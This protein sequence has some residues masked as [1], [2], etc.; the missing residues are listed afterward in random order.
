MPLARSLRFRS[1]TLVAVL[2]LTMALAAVLAYSA[3]DAQRSHRQIAERTLQDYASF[4][5]WEYG[6][7]FKDQLYSMLL[8]IFSPVVHEEKLAEDA[9]LKSPAVLL[10][11]MAQKPRCESD[12][13]RYA[14]RVDWPS[15]KLTLAGREPSAA[16][17]R[18]IR[19]TVVTT[20]PA[21]RHDWTYHAIYGRIDGE[22][23]VIAYQ[24]KWRKSGA[25]AA[26]YG[27]EF[28]VKTLGA[29]GFKKI[30]HEYN[31]LPPTLTK[32]AA[33]ESLFSVV[34]RDE[35]GDT[36]YKSARQ[37]P[38]RYAGDN[39][40]DYFGGIIT[41]VALNPAVA[42]D[43]VIGGLPHSRLALLVG[44]LGL[45]A[46]LVG[47]GLLQLRR[48]AEL[49]RL[50]ADFIASVS[51]ELRTPLAQLRM[52]AETLRL[53]R[54]RSDGERTRSLEIID[55]EARRLTHLVE[56]ILQFSRAERHAL[57]LAPC[58][59]L[60]APQVA[61]ALESF[62]PIARAR[63]ASLDV[64]L[65]ESLSA[66]VDP[67]AFRQ[68]LLN[69][70][71]NAVKY[72]PPGQRIRVALARDDKQAMLTVEDEGPGI[73]AEERERVWT[74]F[75]RLSR[76]VDSAVAGSGIGLSVVRELVERHGGRVRVEAAP[77]QGTRFIVTLPLTQR[78]PNEPALA[79]RAVA[80]QTIETTETTR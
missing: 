69:L 52:F 73:P 35:H 23:H 34:V 32:R 45:S 75:Y 44:A 22:P 1:L 40:T 39:R 28:C 55:Q 3:W 16:I 65:D 13:V 79:T 41:T 25:P 58:D 33:N 12:T 24:V 38:S 63:Q 19:D 21:Y 71:D 47:I 54:V 43:L 18:W 77:R 27:F 62:Q 67:G 74:P 6:A 48:E 15:K 10:T 26:A 80:N 31:L 46:I 61:E 57:R 20:L 51:H 64:S 11:T 8:W 7:S 37:Y 4:A 17:Q 60:L 76:D 78:A 36:L 9:P 29:Y 14:F 56:N 53:G 68:V 66:R 72:G 2:L 5:A 49:A 50:R 70:L 30:M 42:K 59:S